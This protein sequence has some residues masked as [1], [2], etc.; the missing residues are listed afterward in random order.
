MERLCEIERDMNCLY[1]KLVDLANK[2][3]KSNKKVLK[4]QSNEICSPISSYILCRKH[5]L[6]VIPNTT[7]ANQ[8]NIDHNS[9]GRSSNWKNFSSIE[10]KKVNTK[11][12]KTN[13]DQVNSYRQSIWDLLK[14][15]E[16]KYV[17]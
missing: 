2:G 16:R 4:I 7:Y 14:E 15:Q 5:E 12:R 3:P 17:Y 13:I 8:K 6:E 9:F 11:L 1:N 10:P